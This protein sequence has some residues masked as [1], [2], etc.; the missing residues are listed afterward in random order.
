ML[1][2]GTGATKLQTLQHQL[3]EGSE[4]L[5]NQ[6]GALSKIWN[7]FRFKTVSFYETEET[8]T[9]GKVNPHRLMQYGRR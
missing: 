5:E 9:F 2:D 1:K 4:Y 8:P 3:R 7:E 6:K